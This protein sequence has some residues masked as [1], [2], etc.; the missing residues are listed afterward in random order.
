MDRR[1]FLQLGL[2][3]AA[4]L[5]A[6]GAEARP[7]GGPRYGPLFPDPAGFL[8]LPAGFR[9]VV[10][11]AAGQE[12]SDGH[13]VP[14][15]FDGMCCHV[16]DAE[17]YVLL[18]NHEIGDRK[19]VED[20]RAEGAVFPEDRVPVWREDEAVVDRARL[21]G[22]TRVTLHR[23]S[24]LARDPTNFVRASR[25]VLAG[26][27]TN[28]AGGRVKDGWVSCEES[29]AEG[30][31]WAWF[32][33]W[34]AD[35]LGQHRRLDGWGRFRHEA[36]ALLPDGT[37]YMTEDDRVGLLYR[38]RPTKRGDPFGPGRLSALKLP[39]PS[40]HEPG[41]VVVEPGRRWK[42]EWVDIPDPAA[43]GVRCAE[44][45]YAA[46]ATRFWRGEGICTD[47]RHVWFVCT[48]GGPVGAGQVW[49]I[50][51]ARNR[52]SLRHQVSDRTVLSM[53]DNLVFS[54]WGDVILAE[55]N[56]DAEGGA[57]HQHLRG[58]AP[59]GT[60]YPIARNARGNPAHPPGDEFTGPCFSPDGKVLFVNLQGEADATVAIL[61]P[62]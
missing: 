29:L 13:R 30:H 26:T 43:M 11:Q 39:I 35:G 22:V 46:G 47:G 8:D 32:V 4:Q 60:I 21:G 38:F 31:G 33:P 2:L 56:Y 49:E 3:T 37:V 7:R 28:C 36:I 19:F 52:V 62:W 14:G 51:H 40:T 17:N 45:G 10:V 59:D 54:P 48:Q 34:R 1:R 20:E 5:A 55:D 23:P 44:Q 16:D 50:D 41:K 42:A 61:G 53:P 57:T 6:F 9:Y 58:L 25:F 18:R 15:R 24:L 12:M 27:D